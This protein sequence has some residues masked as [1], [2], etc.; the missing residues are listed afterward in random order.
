MIAKTCVAL[1]NASDLLS[2]SCMRA[3]RLLSTQLGAS[4][5]VEVFK[6]ASVRNQCSVLKMVNA[7]PS[8]LAGPEGP[9][10]AAQGRR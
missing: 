4:E 6:L 1:A 7:C 5:Q 8:T 3:L 9:E 10:E 2:A